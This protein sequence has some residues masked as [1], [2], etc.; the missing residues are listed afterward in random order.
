MHRVLIF[1][2]M[3]ALALIV[4]FNPPSAQ[5]YSV[6]D[7]TVQQ[8]WARASAGH[9]QAGAAFMTV[10]NAGDTDDRLVAAE[11]GIAELV[12]LHTHIM[13]DGVMRMRRVEGGIDVPAGGTVALQPGGL[14]VMLIGLNQT[15][16]E[17]ERFP[18][19]LTFEEAGTVT[20][21]VAVMPIGAMQGGMPSGMPGTMGSEPSA[22]SHGGTE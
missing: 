3:L 1:T 17:G 22:Q 15:L 6:G 5:D 10:A 20:V 21:D 2:A 7:I 18:V 16:R 14:H 13:D 9:A 8:P 4:G 19:T 12:E 11:A